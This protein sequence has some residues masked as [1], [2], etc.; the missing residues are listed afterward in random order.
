MTRTKRP[1]GTWTLTEVFTNALTESEGGAV[2]PPETELS[3]AYYEAWNRSDFSIPDRIFAEFFV[4][5]DP[6]SPVPL[7]MGPEGVKGR[8][9]DYRAGSQTSRSRSTTL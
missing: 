4:I 7:V 8:I 5:N 2:S 9:E 3:A 6:G 1:Q